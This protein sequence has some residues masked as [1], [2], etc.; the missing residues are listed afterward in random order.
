MDVGTFKTAQESSTGTRAYLAIQCQCPNT[1]EVGDF[2]FVGDSPRIKG[3]R[4]TPIFVNLQ[5]LY[6]YIRKDWKEDGC[7]ASVFIKR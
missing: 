5:E 7:G 1:E 3:S 2:L 6:N 4:V